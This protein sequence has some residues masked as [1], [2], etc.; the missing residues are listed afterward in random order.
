MR[1]RRARQLQGKFA[2]LDRIIGEVRQTVQTM[3][4]VQLSTQTMNV[5]ASLIKNL[6]DLEVQSTRLE[7]LAKSVHDDYESVRVEAALQ[8]EVTL[9]LF[10]QL[11]VGTPLDTWRRLEEETRRQVLSEWE[12]E[13]DGR[14]T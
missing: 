9:R 2:S 6:E 14:T 3:G 1:P 4:N 12:K 7:T 10:A 11:P 5:N 8:R 13:R